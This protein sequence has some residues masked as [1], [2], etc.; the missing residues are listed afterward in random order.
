VVD[1]G[2]GLGETCVYFASRGARHVYALEP[3]PSAFE[4]ARRNIRR[5]SLESRVTLLNQGGG[6]A[7][8]FVRINERKG[9]T[10]ASTLHS[11]RKGRRV[12]VLTL[13]EIIEQYRLNGVA[14][15]VDCEGCEYGLILNAKDETLAKVDQ[16]V[17]EY[18]Q[19]Y[20]RLA[21]RLRHAGFRVRAEAP[22]FHVSYTDKKKL[23]MGILF[24]Y[25]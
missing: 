19:G 18:H 12:R 23:Y 25:R 14:L 22:K 24:A 4:V 9:S 17:L 5:N 8:S 13:D 7:S 16:I 21:N 11:D 2:A 20:R 3:F 15:K 1:I 6:G 10:P